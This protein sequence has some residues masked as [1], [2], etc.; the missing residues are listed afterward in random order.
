VNEDLFTRAVDLLERYW[1]E[2]ERIYELEFG[3][4]VD[5]DLA[6]AWL[7]HQALV[8]TLREVAPED[9][10]RLVGIYKAALAESDPYEHDP[11]HYVLG[12]VVPRS[13]MNHLGALV[14]DLEELLEDLRRARLLA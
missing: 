10:E 14:A 4:P 2:G 6:D 1:E 7:E 9:R 8:A 13:E 12:D 11:A 3:I 5:K